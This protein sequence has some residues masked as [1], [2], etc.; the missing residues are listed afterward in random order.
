MS[1]FSENLSWLPLIIFPGRFSDYFQEAKATRSG[2]PV[3]SPSSPRHSSRRPACRETMPPRKPPWIPSLALFH[4]TLEDFGSKLSPAAVSLIL[5]E[6]GCSRLPRRKYDERPPG[7]YGLNRLMSRM[8]ESLTSP[9]AGSGPGSAASFSSCAYTVAGS[10]LP[11]TPSS[12]SLGSMPW[13]AV[14][15]LEELL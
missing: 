6:E 12:S 13:E 2:A 10:I 15:L 8:C 11:A 1:G 3:P 14:A 7:I 4:R 5:K 9:P